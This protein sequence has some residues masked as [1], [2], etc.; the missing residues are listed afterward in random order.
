M[1]ETCPVTMSIGVWTSRICGKPVKRDG[2]CGL[3]ASAAER[4][5][6]NSEARQVKGAAAD[7]LDTGRRLA[8]TRLIGFLEA[9]EKM[10]YSDLIYGVGAFPDEDAPRD[11]LVSDLRTILGIQ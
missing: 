2:L 4:R 9:W 6:A 7:A 10:N 11:L 1:T 5:K 8:R 3:H